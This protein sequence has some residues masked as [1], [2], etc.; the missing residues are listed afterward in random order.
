MAKNRSAPPPITE[1]EWVVM[2]ALWT[3][4][5]RTAQ[6][7]HDAVATA[8]DWTLGTVKTLLSRLLRKEAIRHEVDGKRYLYSAAV[9]KR[10]CVKAAG[11]DLLARVHGESKSPLLAFFLKESRLDSGEIQELRDLLDRLE[12]RQQ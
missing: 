10:A 6:G 3:D 1:A 7:I 12:E 2:D 5:P 9:T 4:S 8:Q 11:R